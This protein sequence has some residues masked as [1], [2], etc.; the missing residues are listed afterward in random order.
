[1]MRKK[2]G[3]PS[4]DKNGFIEI[5]SVNSL[6]F[7]DLR[8][9]IKMVLTTKDL[10]AG[11][12]RTESPYNFLERVYHQLD[13]YVREAFHDAVLNHLAD[14]AQNPNSEWREEQIDQLLLLV[15]AIF[16]KSPRSKA[17]LDLLLYASGQE[18]FSRNNKNVNLHWR[19][20]Q[21]LIALQYQTQPEFWYE[22]FRKYGE[23]Y[24]PI[25]ISGLSLIGISKT[26]EWIKENAS[27]KA[28]ITALFR[29]LPL[30]V[31]EHGTTQ[32]SSH[33][34]GLIA[35]IPQKRMADLFEHAERLGIELMEFEKE[36]IHKKMQ[37]TLAESVFKNWKVQEIKG[38]SDQL[39]L[40]IHAK[41]N[42][43][44]IWSKAIS[45]ELLKYSQ[46]SNRFP[47]FGVIHGIAIIIFEKHIPI[48]QQYGEKLEIYMKKFVDKNDPAIDAY[49]L[50]F[51]E[52]LLT[53]SGVNP[54]NAIGSGILGKK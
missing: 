37:E 32:I 27:N 47:D 43:P 5:D 11:S 44:S 31:E 4:V 9:W 3:F 48:S 51:S 23:E 6:S 33:L 14:V 15:A 8:N 17:P 52:A 19:I 25:V 21:T 46:Y 53:Y 10:G 35:V 12:F 45:R 2:R 26:F 39:Q 18:R 29:R 42:T 1:M 38:L 30:M 28:V 34:E 16:G 41:S 20:L 22:Q 24:A 54:K 49:D 7:S 50:Y 40:K 13:S 36:I